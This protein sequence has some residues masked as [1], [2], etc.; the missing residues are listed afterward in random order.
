MKM[1][2]VRWTFIEGVLGTSAANPDIY[3]D[4]LAGRA[5]TPEIAEDEEAVLVVGLSVDDEF[6]KA[7]TI[8]PKLPDGTPFQYDYM[9]K[10]YF[11][12]VCGMLSRL[13]GKDEATGKK[14]KAVNESSKIKA[15]KKEIDGNIFVFP[16][17]IPFECSGE[18]TICQR[19]LRASTPKGERVGL[20]ASE[21]VPAG[22]T[23]TFWVLC[24]ND[25]HV[26]AVMEWFDYG[27]LRGTGQW[28]NSGKGRFTYEI[29]ETAEPKDFREANEIGN[30]IAL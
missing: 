24:L 17:K 26:P 15:F 10:G 16:R 6:Q 2:K 3:R 19:S 30:G 5:P 8:H 29:L 1:L 25:A 21:E 27:I 22:S 11:K 14:G 23:M 12:D 28:R 4:Y 13:T 18:I 9:V 7:M 20:S